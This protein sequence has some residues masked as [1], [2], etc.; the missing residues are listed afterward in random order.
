MN[1]IKKEK[2]TKHCYLNL[3]I[4]QHPKR[5]LIPSTMPKKRSDATVAPP[6]H[7]RLVESINLYIV[8]A[9][10]RYISL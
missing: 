3:K 9:T 1:L 5:F 8:S 4:H 2:K 6:E 7:Q 10:G